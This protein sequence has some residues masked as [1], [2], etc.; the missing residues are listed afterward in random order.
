MERVGHIAWW[1]QGF[2]NLL[3]DEISSRVVNVRDRCNDERNCLTCAR[4]GAVGSCWEA[5]LMEAAKS[6]NRASDN[7]EHLQRGLWCKL[8]IG[9]LISDVRKGHLL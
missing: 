7:A 5:R 6:Y 8:L 9:G 2:G 4:V 1:A 3:V